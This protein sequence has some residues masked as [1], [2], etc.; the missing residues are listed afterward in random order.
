MPRIRELIG[1]FTR[2]EVIAR[3]DSS[4][5]PF[6]PIGKPEDMFE[7]P[8]LTASDGLEPVTLADG[9]E[10]RLPT[11]PLMMGGA[12]PATAAKLPQARADSRAILA[13]LGYDTAEIAALSGQVWFRALRHDSVALRPPGHL[14]AMRAVSSL[15]AASVIQSLAFLSAA[16]RKCQ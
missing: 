12:R 11:L 16:V 3:L 10:T 4:G 8:H 1:G 2:G 9:R 7:D 6:A 15:V 5:F 14:S 13:T